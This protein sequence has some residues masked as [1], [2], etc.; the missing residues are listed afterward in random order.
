M[1]IWHHTPDLS[2]V[3]FD[4]LIKENT[5]TPAFRRCLT[6]QVVDFKRYKTNFLNDMQIL[7]G[8][9]AMLQCNM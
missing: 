4:R 1:V 5:E 2:S 9:P 8:S 7:H 3:N 6:A